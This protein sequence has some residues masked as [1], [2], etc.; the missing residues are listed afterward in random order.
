VFQ[1]RTP[2]LRSSTAQGTR[3]IYHIS[4]KSD[5]LAFD[6][7]VKRHLSGDVQIFTDE[8]VTENELH[9]HLKTFVVLEMR[10]RRLHV[11]FPHLD[12]IRNINADPRACQTH[13]ILCKLHNIVAHFLPLNLIQRYEGCSV[14]EITLLQQLLSRDVGIHHN[15]VQLEKI[16]SP[17][18]NKQ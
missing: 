17:F 10:D 18:D 7:V 13:Q 16:P 11:L 1:N 2:F 14:L 4:F 8:H 12:Q 9:D 3:G 6:A 5:T 15:V